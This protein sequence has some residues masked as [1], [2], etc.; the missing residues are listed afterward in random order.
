MA[1]GIS[2]HVGVNATEAPGISVPRLLGCENDAERMLEIARA[3]NFVGIGD[4][5][6]N[7]IIKRDATLE[8]VLGKIRMAA[9]ELKAGDIFLFTFS[10]HGTRQGEEDRTEGDLQDETLVLHD[11]LLIDNVLRRLLWPAFRPGVRVVMVSDSCHSGGAAMSAPHD[12]DSEIDSSDH[13]SRRGSGGRWSRNGFR[14]RAIPDSQAQAHLE[15]L[16]EF[17]RELQ[18]DLPEQPPPVAANVLLLAACKEHETTRDGHP[19]GVFTMA[20][21]DVWNTNGSKTYKQLMDRIAQKLEEQDA[22]S[23]PVMMSIPDSPELGE[24][25]AFRI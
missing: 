5:P 11:R 12:S 21:L 23:H 20:L 19:N 3:R 18:K 7:P 10:G 17:Y 22:G 13:D 1:T 16:K 25:E 2:I 14:I 8:N 24:T 9:E 15:I 6:D 4:H